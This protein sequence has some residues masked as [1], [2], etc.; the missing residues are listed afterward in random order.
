M[1]L[2]SKLLT[3]SYLNAPRHLIGNE[4][5]NPLYTPYSPFESTPRDSKVSSLPLNQSLI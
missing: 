2:K 1:T 3:I 4:K 5:H